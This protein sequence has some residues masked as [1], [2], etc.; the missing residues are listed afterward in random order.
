MS[1]SQATWGC[2]KLILYFLFFLVA[3]FIYI[4]NYNKKP[5]VI[6]NSDWSSQICVLNSALAFCKMSTD[7]TVYGG[8]TCSALTIAAGLSPDAALAE[9]YVC[10]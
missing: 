3:I 6:L 8:T 4:N 10:H 7:T 5:C 2:V 9:G 1:N